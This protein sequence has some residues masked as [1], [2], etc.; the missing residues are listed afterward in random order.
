VCA[1][2]VDDKQYAM[3]TALIRTKRDYIEKRIKDFIDDYRNGGSGR[4]NSLGFFDKVIRFYNSIFNKGKIQN[5]LNRTIKKT[6]DLAAKEFDETA[7]WL[8]ISSIKDRFDEHDPIRTYLSRLYDED[9]FDGIRNV[10]DL[11]DHVCSGVPYSF[12]SV[13]SHSDEARKIGA[14]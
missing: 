7:R 6:R 3:Y 2:G 10:I 1:N 5:P 8:V 13:S 4:Y 9:D 11:L 14:K 12:Q